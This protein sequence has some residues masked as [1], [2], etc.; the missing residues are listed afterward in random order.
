MK[1]YKIM[2]LVLCCGLLVSALAGCAPS[3]TGATDGHGCERDQAGNATATAHS[4]RRSAMRS[5]RGGWVSNIL[6]HTL[7]LPWSPMEGD[8]P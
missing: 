4:S 3:G 1:F 8:V 6:F 7:I 2:A 5:S